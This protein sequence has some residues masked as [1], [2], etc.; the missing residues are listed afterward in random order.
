[1]KRF[2]LFLSCVTAAVMFSSCSGNIDPEGEET[3]GDVSDT[4]NVPEGVLRI[5]ADKAEI[6]ADGADEVTFTIMFGSEDVSNAKTLQLV[7]IYEGEEKY[8]AYGINKFSTSTAGTFK[9][10]AEFY[11]AGKHYTDNVVEILAKPYQVGETKNFAR[12][13]LAAYFTSTGCT[14]CPS[15]YR[16]IKEVQDANPGVV[17]VVAFHEHKTVNDPMKTPETD[18]FRASFGNFTDLPRLFWNL[19]PGTNLNGPSFKTSFA[20]EIA[21]YEP[22]C[23]VA[24]TTSYDKTSRK[25]DV[26]VGIT[27]NLHAK[28][29]YLIFLVEDN[30]DSKVLGADYKQCGDEYVHHNVVRDVLATSAAGEK[31]ND[32][33]P[34][35]PGVEATATKSVVLPEAWNSDNMRI[36]VSAMTSTDGGTTWVANNTNECKIGESVSY[37]YAE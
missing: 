25:L 35:T 12:N 37:E 10:K 36:V 3:G 20:E 1:M 26:E 28:Y 23:G 19:R 32:N 34:L 22:Q 27:S 2:L 18:L 5:F 15:A 8:M 21:A 11:Y 17:S 4:Q 33:L 14:S 9:F 30:M 29:R 24:V 13:V 7:R 16:E 31:I 6:M